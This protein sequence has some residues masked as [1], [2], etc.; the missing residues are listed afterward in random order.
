MDP[1]TSSTG[2]SGRGHFLARAEL[3]AG[4]GWSE[5][6]CARSNANAAETT[7]EASPVS[8]NEPINRV[9][10]K[11]CT[12]VGESDIWTKLLGTDVNNEQI[13]VG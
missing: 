10:A 11:N 13:W 9:A 4:L 5:R 6:D 7:H 3:A 1:L 8:M 12:A 2:D